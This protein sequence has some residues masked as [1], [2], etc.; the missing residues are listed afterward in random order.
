MLKVNF[1]E[2][3]DDKLLEF[4]V[5]VARHK[6]RWV[7]CKHKN[8]DTYECPG[9]HRE[10]DE[11]ILTCA[12]RELW[13]ETGAVKFEL[14]PVCVYSVTQNVINDF[15]DKNSTDKKKY[16]F[17]ESAKFLQNIFGIIPLMYGSL[18]LEYLTNKN[19]NADDIDILIPKVFIND[20]WAEFKTILKENGYALTDEHEH[21]FEKDGIYYSYAEIEELEQFANI[22]IPDITTVTHDSIQFKLLS[23]QQYLDVYIASSKDGYRVNIREKKDLEK[24]EF[25]KNH[26]QNKTATTHP[27]CTENSKK[28]ETFGM[29]Y[30]AEIS[31]FGELPQLEIEKVE[32]FK[33]LPSAWTYPLIQPK[34]IEKTQKLFDI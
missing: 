19:L 21:T 32:L 3:I 24:I 1:Y 11:N 23:L 18:G 30:F 5:I 2:N 26:L 22:S 12:K 15:N 27:T 31:E 14:K 8:Q 25:I 4:A 28:I 17:F 9:G 33:D 10:I 7:F 34:L 6:G 29:L 20:R 16:A 13:E